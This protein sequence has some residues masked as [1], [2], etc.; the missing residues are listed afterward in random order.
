M[1]YISFWGRNASIFSVTVGN[2]N[3]HID[4]RPLQTQLPVNQVKKLRVLN[5]K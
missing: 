1:F 4:T 5:K 3:T 2:V